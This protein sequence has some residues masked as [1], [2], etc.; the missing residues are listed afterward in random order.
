MGTIA[1]SGVLFAALS[2][3]AC[4]PSLESRSAGQVGCSPEEIS[5]SS[6]QTHFG[7]LQSAETWVAE[8]HGRTFI[9][10]QMNE[11]SQ[12]NDAASGL[13]AS[14]QVSCAEEAESPE[15]ERNGRLYE[16]ALAAAAAPKA[17][18]APP[19]GA[20]GFDWGESQADAQQ[21][22]VASGH[23]WNLL[24][25]DTPICSGAAADLGFPASVGLRFCAGRAC[26][27][28]VQHRPS[29]NWSSR[30]VTLKA[31]LETKYGAPAETSGPI[32]Q[33]CRTAQSFAQCLDSNKLTLRYAWHWASGE[34]V[35]MLVGKPSAELPAQI[36]LLYTR[37][38]GAANAAAL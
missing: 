22:C 9:C 38:P 18:S 16:A 2:L 15:A 8:C 17:P 33:D 14:E 37:T 34:S 5:I 20:A 26:G 30:V 31:Q 4:V 29:G 36:R 12:H 7:L 24:A 10:S 6:E 23:Q 21:R 1:R 32:P 35:E 25:D 11:T 28:A 19:V 27:I 13:L 3:G